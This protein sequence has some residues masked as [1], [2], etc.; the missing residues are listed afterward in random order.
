MLMLKHVLYVLGG[1]VHIFAKNFHQNSHRTT[2]KYKLQNSSFNK[3]HEFTN[4]QECSFPF[5][6]FGTAYL[7][8][9]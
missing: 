2:S 9:V 1:F 8:K 4:E 3:Q 5:K 6:R 7:D